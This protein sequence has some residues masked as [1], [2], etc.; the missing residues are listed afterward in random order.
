M[1]H[2]KCSKCLS[3]YFYLI[4]VITIHVV[5]SDAIKPQLI[6]VYKQYYFMWRP[7]IIR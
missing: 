5:D 2:G 7:G 1:A 6:L 3:S 4:V